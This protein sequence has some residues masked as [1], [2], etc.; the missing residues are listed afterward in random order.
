MLN[1]EV[2]DVVVSIAG[3]DMGN[4]YIVKEIDGNYL[5]LVDGKGKTNLKPKLK[6]VKHTRPTG[7]KCEA[8]KNKWLS[9]ERVLDAEIRKTIS[10]LT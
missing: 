9:Q 8:L 2:G 7:Q 6:K 1:I 5:H 10:N 4:L 3:R